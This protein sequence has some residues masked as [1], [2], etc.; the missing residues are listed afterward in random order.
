[1]RDDSDFPRLTPPDDSFP[2]P[3]RLYREPQELTDGQFDL[4]A[5]A[6]AEGA[7][8]EDSLADMEAAIDA[9]P[10]RLIRAES[11]RSIKVTPYNDKWIYRDRLLR[12]SPATA[13]IRRSLVLTLLAAAAVIAFIIIW[14]STAREATDTLPGL[15]QESTAMSEALIPEGS[16]IIIQGS[17]EEPAAIGNAEATRPATHT[18]TTVTEKTAPV[19]ETTG[20]A[21]P[22][23]VSVTHAAKTSVMIAAAEKRELRPV[24]MQIITAAPI[25]STVS[26]RLPAAGK[27]PNWVFRGISTLAKAITK[28][29]K[30][31]DGYVVASACVNGINNFLGWEM[32]LEQSSNNEGQPVAV[33]FSSSLISVSAPVNKNLP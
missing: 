5:A 33:N 29:E 14:P 1:M 10:S 12:Q 28:E 8:A 3:D 7:L 20:A 26:A 22:K 2:G 13:A 32:E 19:I 18:L 6:W 30:N 31:I 21:K 11:F 4:L 9:L 16:P 17:V 24:E 25:E 27:E 15:I 23:P